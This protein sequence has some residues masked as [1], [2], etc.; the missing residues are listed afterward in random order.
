MNRDVALLIEGSLLERLLQRAGEQGARFAEVRR[1]S[2]RSI[3]VHADEASA[4][5]LLE[6]CRKYGL[7]CRVLS[8]GG[9]S[10]LKRRLQ[11]RWTLLI[12]LTL[13][14]AVCWV[15]LS[16][17]WWIDISFLGATAQLG[18]E[19]EVRACLREAGIAP[20]MALSEIDTSLL[21][22][23]L[24]ASAGDFSFVGVRRQGVRLW[25]EAACEQP[26]PEVYRIEYAR[27][28]VAAQ[29]GV[30]VSL[31]VKSGEAA[32]K[33]GD[34]VRRG[35]ILISGE[36]AVGK[37]RESG[38]EITVGVSALGEVVAR[39][40]YEGSAE[41][42]LIE[43]IHLPTG[44]TRQSR[45]LR[46]LGRRITL[47]ACESFALERVEE[48]RVPIVG[49]LLPVEIERSVHRELRVQRREIDPDA[50]AERLRALAQAEAKAR[51]PEGSAFT[52]WEERTQTGNT[53]RIRAVYEV[54]TNIAV[55]RE[56]LA[57]SD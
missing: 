23:Q 12:G 31:N 21:Q 33:V 4:Q 46:L 2:A 41:G 24:M 3:R 35:Q 36:E 11:A 34:T 53:L 49:L 15:A 29:D 44:R 10:A 7:N 14:A 26:S 17:L 52:F 6:L 39:C 13:C 20:G 45:R 54:Q 37:D 28:L 57:A 55:S 8:R 5:L 30:I 38:E 16:R 19:T 42:E 32:V 50:L 40:W 27:D 25:V 9:W 22:K 47:A 56:A 1:V 48:E 51:L 43:E 18:S